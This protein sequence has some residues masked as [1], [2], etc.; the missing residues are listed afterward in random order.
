MGLTLWTALESLALR[1]ELALRLSLPSWRFCS[2]RFFLPVLGLPL[3]RCK[4][5]VTAPCFCTERTVCEVITLSSVGVIFFTFLS[6]RTT[7]AFLPGVGEAD[8]GVGDGDDDAAI[9]ADVVVGGGQLRG[10]GGVREAGG[11]TPVM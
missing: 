7:A 9:A 11:A 3:A 8:L 2:I 4:E 10:L 1:A 6:T 5:S